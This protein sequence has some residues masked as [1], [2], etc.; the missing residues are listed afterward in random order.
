[1]G[2]WQWCSDPGAVLT[3]KIKIFSPYGVENRGD[4]D[5]RGTNE[6]G[7]FDI[8]NFQMSESPES[9]HGDPDDS[10]WLVHKEIDLLFGE[11]V[12]IEVG[13]MVFEQG[14]WYMRREI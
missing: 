3:F 12:L 11:N 8:S 1:M 2:L 5:T 10:H 14:I 6:V 7:D 13:V 9:T 4:S